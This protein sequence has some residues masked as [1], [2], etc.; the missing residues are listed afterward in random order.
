MRMLLV[1]QHERAFLPAAQEGSRQADNYK[2]TRV[3]HVDSITCR[4]PLLGGGRAIG[5]GWNF[6]SRHPVPP[7]SIQTGETDE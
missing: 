2:E 6:L 5:P 3:S 4:V 1:G 7:S